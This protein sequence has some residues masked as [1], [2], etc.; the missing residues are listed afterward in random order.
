MRPAWSSGA[1]RVYGA[2]ATE[3]PSRQP[4]A[5]VVVALVLLTLTFFYARHGYANQGLF[6]LDKKLNIGSERSEALERIF[7]RTDFDKMSFERLLRGIVPD[8]VLDTALEYVKLMWGE[9]VNE[10]LIKTINPLGEVEVSIDS[11]NGQLETQFLEFDFNRVHSDGQMAR[12]LV[13][14]ID[15]TRRVELARELLMSIEA[16]G[17]SACNDLDIALAVADRRGEL[18][19]GRGLARV[20][21]LVDAMRSAG[22]HIDLE[23]EGNAASFTLADPPRLVVDLEGVK[24][25]VPKQKVE[26]GGSLVQRVRVGTHADKVRV[27]VDGAPGGDPF[28]ELVPLFRAA[29]ADYFSC[30]SMSASRVASSGFTLCL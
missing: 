1:A 21:E 19:P 11:G 28:D 4:L 13:T 30:A 14:V 2:S 6:L 7:H 8:K 29:H 27:V 12:L 25:V 26:V 18:A 24:S 22:L 20:P 23:I 10:K 5:G 16:V 3:G 15:V 17:R 9:R